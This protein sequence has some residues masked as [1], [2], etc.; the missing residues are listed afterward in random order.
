VA[1]TSLALI[2]AILSALTLPARG[3][4]PRA[5]AASSETTTISG[6]VV[7]DATGDPIPNVRITVTAAAGAS[8]VLTDSD[9]RFSLLAPAGPH[10]I[11]AGKSAY[12]RYEMAAT[13]GQPIEIR[14]RRGA[15]ISGRV[16]DDFGEPVIGARV[17][18]ARRSSSLPDLTTIAIAETDDRGEYRLAT[19]PAGSFA[20]AVT[21]VT[22]AWIRE[23][24]GNRQI[25]VRPNFQK[26]YYP[27]VSQLEASALVV[28]PGEDRTGI[29]FVVPSTLAGNQPLNTFVALPVRSQTRPLDP[30]TPATGRIRGRVVSS[31]GRALPY[32][33]VVLI[34]ERL[35]AFAGRADSAGMF[36]FLEVAAGTYRFGG[37]KAG[38][39][40][41]TGREPTAPRI[42]LADGAKRDDMEIALTR[43]GTVAGRILD[44][45]GDPMQGV[46]IQLLHVRYEA[47]RRRLVP[48]GETTTAWGR[49][50]V[51]D[52]VGGYR[53]FGIAPGQYIVSAT[54][55]DVSSTDVPGYARSY[56]PGAPTPAEA[57]FILVG[58]AQD[59]AG[60]DLTLFRTHTARIAGRM[61]NTAGK[62]TGGTLLLLPSQRSASVT[63]VPVGARIL[64]DGRFEFPNVAPGRYVIQ[65]YRGR[66]NRWTE[67]EF[68]ALPVSVGDADVSD[69]VL[70]MSSGSSVAGHFSFDTLD[71]SKEPSP[72]GIDFSPI[73]VDL[74][75]SPQ[76]NL[77]TANVRPDGSF[78]MAGISGSRRLQLL[79]APP[80]WALKEIRVNGVDITD[81]PLSFG[82][83]D[84]SLTGVVVV[85][86]DRVSALVGTVRAEN[87]RPSPGA[88]LIVF[89]ADR[90]EW[91]PT[92]RFV[93]KTAAGTDGVFAL[94]GLP[95]GTY[96][97]AAV[98]QLPS[99]GEEA[100]Q[101]PE[102]LDAL[103]PRAS[104][105]TITEGQQLSLN[106]QVAADTRR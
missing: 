76:N 38:Y 103:I 62:P 30:A 67:G 51:T 27:G 79:S 55:G 10:N 13:G 26:T 73:P 1:R 71:T 11:V 85:L 59:V 81:R 61:L 22:T 80:G 6:R 58:P 9:G 33:Q 44:E 46:S 19:L 17:T 91:Y 52:D 34:S 39:F 40:P 45:Y 15:A 106:V 48:A 63:N 77:A 5:P 64:T 72:S 101:D 42:D 47:G 37:S 41:V 68:G 31:D 20:V 95:S 21:T 100:W 18:A 66:S 12:A 3:Q 65:V 25:A 102:F 88:S 2:A 14:L 7:A 82:R 60:I 74:D 93:R 29:D 36:E 75:L 50:R 96:Y 70:Q 99:D 105:I 98:A 104:T 23:E 54:I 94:T 87:A 92:S 78:E 97:A 43:W 69:V 8:V 49:P 86:T 4:S 35:E 24:T 28:Q 53:L 83:K 56:F 84:Q 16:V 57:Q 90:A 89:S 32:A